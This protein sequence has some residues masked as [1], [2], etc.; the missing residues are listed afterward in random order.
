MSRIRGLCDFVTEK[1][2][3][4]VYNEY[5]IRQEEQLWK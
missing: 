3:S 5:I 1:G 2:D 4:P